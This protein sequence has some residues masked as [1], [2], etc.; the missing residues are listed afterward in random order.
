MVFLPMLLVTLAWVSPSTADE[1]PRVREFQASFGINAASERIFLLLPMYNYD[2][3]EEYRLVCI[4]GST[5]YLDR[6][7]SEMG[8]IFVDPLQCNLWDRAEIQHERT[9]L[10]EDGSPAWHT[11]GQFSWHQLVGDCGDYP[12]YGRLRHF[13]LRGFELHP[14]GRRRHPDGRPDR[15]LCAHRFASAK[16][17]PYAQAARSRTGYMRPGQA[18]CGVVVMGNAPRRC[19]DPETLAWGAMQ[20][21]VGHRSICLRS[22]W[23]ARAISPNV[24]AHIRRETP[25][26]HR[27]VELPRIPCVPVLENPCT[28]GSSKLPARAFDNLQIFKNPGT[29]P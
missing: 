18:G 29:R 14:G 26:S 9:L 27:S 8:A 13:R 7:S 4:G 23:T 6:L 2:N 5:E 12:E 22:H 28:R 24:P 3:N 1:W 16:T 11:R 17:V 25:A 21:P 20:R 19:R 15:L 10:G